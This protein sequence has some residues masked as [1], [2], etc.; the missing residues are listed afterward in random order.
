MVTAPAV[1][2]K[3]K[4]GYVA[5]FPPPGRLLLCGISGAHAY[6]FP[7]QDSDLDLKGLHLVDTDALLGLDPDTAAYDRTDDFE[8][9]ECDLT[10]NEA[11]SALKLLVGGNG[12][13][14][15]RILSRY[16]L[17]DPSTSEEVRELQA[18]AQGALSRRFARHYGGFFRGC[19]REHEREPTAKTM[20][21][22]Y[23]VAL[24]GIHLLRTGQLNANLAD[25]APDYGFSDVDE[26]IALKR[27]A[28]EQGALPELLDAQHRTRWPTLDAMLGQSKESSSLPTECANSDDVHAWL[29][30]TRRRGLGR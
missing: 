30:Q 23:R 16:Q 5:T 14:A 17:I 21:Y 1:A 3:S 24:T 15:E 27:S 25:L 11:G 10:T 28:T 29:V 22:S 8:G 7:S 20:L 12:N 4:P 18:L 9:T 19:C 2:P 13:M 26:L 6:G